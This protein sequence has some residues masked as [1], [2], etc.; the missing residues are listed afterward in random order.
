MPVTPYFLRTLPQTT[1]LSGGDSTSR[2]RER[3]KFERSFFVLLLAAILSW[4]LRELC[5]AVKKEGL[6]R[7]LWVNISSWKGV[8]SG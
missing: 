4:L 1:S 7:N 6:Q 5:G 8:W 2:R 3:K